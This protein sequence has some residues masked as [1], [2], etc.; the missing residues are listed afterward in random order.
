MQIETF[1]L[2]KWINENSEIA[3]Y[4]LSSTC[5]KA[6]S[7]NDL[8]DLCEF[9]FDKMSKIKLNYGQLYGTNAL[10]SAICNLYEAQK[11]KNITVTLGGIGANQLA[12]QTLI[13]KNDKVVCV[14]PCYQ[15]AYSLPR[16]YGADV[17][18]VFL[19]SKDWSLDIENFKKIV[20]EDTKLICLTNPNNPSGT[21]LKEL[22][23]VINIARKCGAYVLADEVYR[24][25]SHNDNPYTKSVADIYEKGISTGSMSKTYSLAGVRLGWICANS[26]LINKINSNREYNTISISALDDF[27]ATVALENHKKIVARNLEIIRKNK[28]ILADFINSTEKL[29]W[30]EPNAGSIACVNY[31]FD[32]NS[33][34]FCAKIQEK[35]GILLIPAQCFDMNEKFFRIGYGMEEKILQ[36]ALEK[37]YDA[38]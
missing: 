20:G 1:K 7:L 17:C 18:L 9:D 27:V 32:V 8:A 36:E 28:Q 4:D 31:N 6:L 37:F 29:N 16:F 2:E 10:K 23:E 12:L 11:P 22:E 13:E 14:C 5:V 38:L 3:K 33:M 26:E 25:L 34:E 35:T 19:N 24:G 15:Q 21:V 30:V